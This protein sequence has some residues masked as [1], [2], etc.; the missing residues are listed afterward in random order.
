MSVQA[1]SLRYFSNVFSN[2]FRSIPENTLKPPSKNTHCFKCLTRIVRISKKN[3][4]PSQLTL[5]VILR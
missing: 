1:V 5:K 3:L 2:S 4:N